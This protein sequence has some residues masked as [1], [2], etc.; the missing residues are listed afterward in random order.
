MKHISIILFSFISLFCHSQD[1]NAI[2]NING[3]K[4]FIS[5]A[6]SGEPIIALHGGPGLNHS[7]F[8]PHL[9]G[10]E[11]NFRVI[12]YDQ[13]A[14]GQSA[15]PSP[16]SISI[17]FLV[18]DLE[19]I[20]KEFKIEKLNLLAHS[21]GA[22]LGAHYALKYPDHVRRIIFSN[23]AF[24]SREY[25][26]EAGELT[27]KKTTKE[28]STQRA[29]VMA[30]GINMTSAQAEQLFRISFR[31]S[32]FNRKNIDRLNL[33][34]P[35]NFQTANRNLFGGLMKDP[36][37]RKNLYDS[38]SKMKFPA[39]VIH[40]EA[41]ILPMSSIHRL[42]SNLPYGELVVLNSSGHFPFLEEQE[43]YLMIVRTFFK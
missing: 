22:L 36:E 13:R 25:D 28:D 42:K 7:Y 14:C 35:E 6:G 12:Y 11:K 2:R 27:K 19:E 24:F 21:W 10:L 3:T 29:S 15:I 4:L 26:R 16:D 1:F 37:M 8:K 17:Q 5:V 31:A 9:S 30:A 39:L 43:N 33:N 18:N 23:P 40:G 20:R 41:D 34:I 32:A 38:L